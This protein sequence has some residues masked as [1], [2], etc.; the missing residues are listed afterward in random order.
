MKLGLYRCRKYGTGNDRR[1]I[2]KGYSEKDE[3]I[4]SAA[5]QKTIDKVSERIWC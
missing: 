1:N 2:G 5:T 3:I 4:A